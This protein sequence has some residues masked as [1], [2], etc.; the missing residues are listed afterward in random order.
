MRDDL[1]AFTQAYDILRRRITESTDLLVPRV[2]LLH[3]WSGSRAVCG[4]LELSIHAIERSIAEYDTLI[5]KIKM[6]EL[7]N[8]DRP[9][10]TVLDGGLS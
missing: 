3:Q 1:L 5:E 4:S 9:K 8:T 2:P 7:E 10:L 6:G